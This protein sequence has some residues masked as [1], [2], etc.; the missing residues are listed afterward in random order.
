MLN[1]VFV[2]NRDWNP[3]RSA[4]VKNRP[5]IVNL[6]L[7][8]VPQPQ[9]FEHSTESF[10][11][12]RKVMESDQLFGLHRPKTAMTNTVDLNRPPSKWLL[13]I[14]SLRMLFLFAITP[15][16]PDHAFARLQAV[17]ASRSPVAMAI[18]GTG[19][20]STKKAARVRRASRYSRINWRS[21][22][23]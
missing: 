7:V 16:L 9:S 19:F 5:F 4:S 23:E 1:Q 12:S 10:S 20:V 6:P 8:E 22:M 17:C 21:R 3:D 2:T 11:D 18:T 14:S 15:G 13:T